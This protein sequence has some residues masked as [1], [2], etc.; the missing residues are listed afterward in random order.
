[1]DV[2]DRSLRARLEAARLPEG[3][4][5][6]VATAGFQIEGGYN[7]AH[8]ARGWPDPAV[9]TN[10]IS[11]A[12]HELD[13]GLVDSRGAPAGPASRVDG[14]AP[15]DGRAASS[16]DA[17]RSGRAVSED[18]GMERG[19][20]HGPDRPAAPADGPGFDG[21]DSAGAYGEMIRALRG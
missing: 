7:D 6:G 5:F 8:A 9:T 1:M 14:G 11:F 19:L 12:V 2:M 3:F 10:L 15:R 17:A 20:Q 18:G 21:D 13:R 16:A 4:A